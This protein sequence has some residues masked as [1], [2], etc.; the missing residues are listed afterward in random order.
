MHRLAL[1]V[2]AALLTLPALAAGGQKVTAGD[3][4]LQVN[5]KISPAVAGRKSRPQGVTFKLGVDYESLN[6]NAQ[7]S[8]STKSI[9]LSLPAGM[10][11]NVK[12]RKQCL[13][14]RLSADG[15]SACPRGSR[16]GQGTATADARPTLAEPVPAKVTLYNGLDDTNPD[17]SPRSPAVPA[18]ILFA[19]TDLGLNTVLPFDLS[20]SSMRLDYAPSRPGEKP[21]FHLQKVSLTFPGAGRRSYLTAPTRCTSSWTVGL[22]IE[23]FD[24]PSIAD[25]RD[26]K[27]RRPKKRG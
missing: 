3:Q 4:S 6:P 19:Q 24:G 7:V 1:L 25:T 22:A 12:S 21:L 16:V 23:N 11:V 27:C 18:V 2:P 8:E 9:T 26:V 13:V 14:S 20:G 5:A 17:G 15:P 10:K